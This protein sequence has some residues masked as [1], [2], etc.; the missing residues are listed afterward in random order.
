MPIQYILPGR[1]YVNLKTGEIYQVFQ[2]GSHSETDEGLIVYV[3]AKKGSSFRHRLGLLFLRFASVLLLERIW[4]RPIQLF[5][6][7]FKELP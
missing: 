7:K 3:P 5:A 4:L 2:V 6:T 1:K